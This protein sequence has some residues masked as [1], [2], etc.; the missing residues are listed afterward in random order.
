MSRGQIIGLLQIQ[1]ESFFV[2]IVNRGGGISRIVTAGAVDLDDLGP[3]IR[4]QHTGQWTSNIVA[5]VDD[6][7]AA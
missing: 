1:L 6:A 4:Q 5:E 3:L 2:T 7:N